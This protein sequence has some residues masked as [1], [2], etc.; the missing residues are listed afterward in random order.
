MNRER[1]SR[2]SRTAQNARATPTVLAIAATD[3]TTGAGIFADLKTLAAHGVYGLAAV[4]AV[5]VQTRAG[6]T[7]VEPLAAD[8]VEQQIAAACASARPAAIKIGMLASGDIA[9]AVAASLD[10]CVPA[11][12]PVVLDPVLAS[13]SGAPLLRDPGGADLR[14]AL[15][16]RV[17]LVT[18]NLPEAAALAGGPVATRDDMLRAATTLAGFGARAV[19]VKGGHLA[20]AADDLLYDAASGDTVWFTGARIPGIDLHGTGCALSS[21]IAAQLARQQPL[22]DAVAHAREYVRALLERGDA[23][24]G[25]GRGLADHLGLRKF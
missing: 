25:E 19:L 15:L 21:A 16:P 1:P 9:R 17:A 22:V 5:T 6:V 7:R 10:A 23:I 3:P 8:L 14:R 11:G 13:S 18:P 20:D 24:G 2:A 12:T 4:T